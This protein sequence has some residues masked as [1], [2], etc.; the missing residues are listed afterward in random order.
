MLRSEHDTNINIDHKCFVFIYNILL[1]I[2]IKSLN[3]CEYNQ[4]CFIIIPNAFRT[5]EF[6]TVST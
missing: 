5:V 6:S 3:M 4:N 1:P 2:S